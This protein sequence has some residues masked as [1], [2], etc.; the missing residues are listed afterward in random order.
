MTQRI[1]LNI[2]GRL[3]ARDYFNNFINNKSNTMS[4]AQKG[5]GP[6]A[7]PSTLSDL[8]LTVNDG[9]IVGTISPD[10]QWAGIQ[11]FVD[12]ATNDGAVAIWEAQRNFS[13]P[14][15]PGQTTSCPSQGTGYYRVWSSDFDYDVHLSD[16]VFVP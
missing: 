1:N 6:K 12:P 15:G 10:A 5:K 7:V 11:K 14:P 16:F 13:S 9:N 3:M 4:K 8:V 2:K